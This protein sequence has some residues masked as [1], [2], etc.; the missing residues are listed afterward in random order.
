MK[1]EGIQ[2][3]GT[4]MRVLT[5]MCQYINL[6]LAVT[7]CQNWNMFDK[8]NLWKELGSY[9]CSHDGNST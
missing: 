4:L 9:L 1:E 2:S 5:C 3:R 8:E 7:L 6:H